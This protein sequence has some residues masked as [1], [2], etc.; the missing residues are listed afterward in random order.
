M[1]DGNSKLVIFPTID[2]VYPTCVPDHPSAQYEP[3]NITNQDFFLEL[4]E[5][6]ST[7]NQITQEAA[8]HSKNVSRSTLTFHFFYFI[9]LKKYG[10]AQDELCHRKLMCSVT[11]LI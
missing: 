11:E 9:N 6:W 5:C 1:Q 8:E 10:Y 7:R 4:L 3:N 2:H